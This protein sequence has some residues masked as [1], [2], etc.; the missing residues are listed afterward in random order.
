MMLSLLNTKNNKTTRM[1][2]AENYIENLWGENFETNF[3]KFVNSPRMQYKVQVERNSHT[4]AM[5]SIYKLQ[6]LLKNAV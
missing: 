1:I 4:L 5:K 2:T 6:Q 3:Q